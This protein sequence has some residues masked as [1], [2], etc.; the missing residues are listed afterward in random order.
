MNEQAA[1]S[2]QRDHSQVGL[3][4]LNLTAEPTGAD[5]QQ[6]LGWCVCSGPLPKRLT[7]ASG[8]LGG[9][10]RGEAKFSGVYILSL[11][12][13]AKLSACLWETQKRRQKRGRRGTMELS[14]KQ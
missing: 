10:P 3:P 11:A 8:S 14:E 4:E 6:L 13:H 7:K 12:G 5:G 2:P 9:C 1:S